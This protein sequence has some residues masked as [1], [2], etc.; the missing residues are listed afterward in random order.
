MNWHL[1]IKKYYVKTLNDISKNTGIKYNT[2]VQTLKLEQLKK[3]RKINYDNTFEIKLITDVSLK[4]DNLN[5][6]L[7]HLQKYIDWKIFKIIYYIK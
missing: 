2:L 4:I 3:Y 7:M 6:L 5:D 1:K